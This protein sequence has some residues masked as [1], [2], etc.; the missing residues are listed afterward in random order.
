MRAT[1]ER[2][3]RSWGRLASGGFEFDRDLVARYVGPALEGAWSSPWNEG[4]ALRMAMSVG[5]AMSG[6]GEA[7]WY[8]L[9]RLSDGKLEGRVYNDASPAR[10]LPGSIAV[11]PDGRRFANEGDLFQSFG[12]R[13]SMVRELAPRRGW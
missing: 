7:Q 1:R 10:H 9:L 5:A 8:A 3:Q 2:Q 12:E 11:G 13:S 4:D 6:L